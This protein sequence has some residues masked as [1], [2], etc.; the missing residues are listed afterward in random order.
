MPGCY[1]DDERGSPRVKHG[2]RKT[3][4]PR[5]IVS[6]WSFGGQLRTEAGRAERQ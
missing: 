3:R 2:S 5:E 6:I 1:A 4:G